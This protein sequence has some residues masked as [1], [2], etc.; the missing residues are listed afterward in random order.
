MTKPVFIVF[1]A[2]CFAGAKPAGADE[3]HRRPL[4][5]ADAAAGKPLY[6]R[7]C[8]GCHG[9]RGNGAGPAAEYV[10]PR[11]RDF[12]QARFKFRTTAPGQP[13]ATKDILRTIQRGIPGSAMPSF[14]FLSDDERTKIAAYVLRLADLLD[15]PEPVGL[16]IGTPPPATAES[17]A[18][19]KEL[20]PD[21]GCTTCHGV[22]GKGDGTSAKDLKDVTGRPI[23]PRD[24]TQG[25]YHG[26]GERTDIFYRLLTGLDGTPM[27]S[28]KDSIDPPELWQIVDYVLSLK[29]PPLAKPRPADPILAGRDVAAKYSCRG[30]HV[31]DDGVGGSVG[32]DL[33]ISAQKLYPDW[34]RMFLK[35]PREYGKIYPWRVWRMPDLRLGDEDV[36]IMAKYLGAIGKRRDA[37]AVLPEVASFAADKL[38][39]GKLYFVLRC[40][41]CHTLGDTIVTPLAKQQGPDLARVAGRVDYEWA[42]KWIVN[43]KLIDPNTRMIIPDLTP[44]QVDM[45]RMFVWKTSV[46]SN[47]KLAAAQD[48]QTARSQ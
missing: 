6:L 40:A 36:D 2:L 47:H 28:Y 44:E 46:E 30:C 1:L 42:K 26:G 34:V 12:T 7:E 8:S 33:R 10:D 20:F 35:A 5:E 24:L 32:P 39:Q 3:E 16:D 11:P 45:V 13:P 18:K 27:P 19:G 14:S 25:V 43:P 29:Q 4:T 21:A 15:G 31:L 23:R 48:S 41:E 37:P 9:E 38:D 17:I 22:S